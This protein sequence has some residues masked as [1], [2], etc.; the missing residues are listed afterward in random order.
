MIQFSN[1]RVNK[2][3]MGNTIVE[4]ELLYTFVIHWFN[5][6][7]NVSKEISVHQTIILRILSKIPSDKFDANKRFNL[8]HSK[9]RK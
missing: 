6:R 1:P 7:A 4:Y 3:D 2:P 8:T 9:K 5:I